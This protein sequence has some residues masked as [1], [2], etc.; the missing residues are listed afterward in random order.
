MPISDY[1][2]LRIEDGPIS[3]NT[4]RTPLQ[5]LGIKDDWIPEGSRLRKEKTPYVETLSERELVKSFDRSKEHVKE[6]NKIYDDMYRS[7]SLDL[8]SISRESYLSRWSRENTP[9][10]S[11]DSYKR[12]VRR[13]FT[14]VRDVSSYKI[15]HDDRR[16]T[17]SY[18]ARTPLGVV[19]APYHTNV[20]YYSESQ[21]IRKYDVFQLRTWSYPIY[22]YLNN[23]EY[24]P[25]RP[26]SYTRRYANTSLYTPPKMT[27]EIRPLTS[28][29]GYSGYNYIAGDTNYNIATKPWSISNYRFW[30]SHVSSS[31]WYWS[32]YGYGRNGTR[33]YNSYRPPAYT[34]RLSTY[35]KPYF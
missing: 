18:R 12:H 5:T 3:V 33:H 32:H 35:W 24:D 23:R 20:N 26:Y 2:K 30:R 4:H 1:R 22:K 6:I 14:P 34:S 25:G 17:D 16:P 29:S 9:I 21:P 13:S 27:A 8:S 15:V 11:D 10:D 28:R 19:T 7:R 31:P